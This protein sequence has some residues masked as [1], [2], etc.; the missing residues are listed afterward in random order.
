MVRKRKQQIQILVFVLAACFLVLAGCAK[1]DL[2][3]TTLVSTSPTPTAEPSSSAT[4]TDK[5]ENGESS[6][7]RKVTTVTGEI[8]I[9]ANPQR[10]VV[11]WYIGDVFTL[12]FEPAGIYAWAQETMPFYDKFGDIPIIEKWDAESIMSLDP[13]LIVT[14]DPL[15]ADKFS[16]IA[17]VLVVPETTVSPVERLQFLGEATG[18]EAE[19]KAAIKQFEDKLAEAQAELNADIFKDKTFSIFQDWGADSY[20]VFYETG[21]RGG[22]LLYEHLHLKKPQKLEELVKD[23]GNGRGSLSYEVAA[24]YF[25]DYVIWFLMEDK[26]SEFAQTEIWKSIP[27]VA[28]G[29]I[30]E[31][32]GEYTGLFFYSDVVSMTA[33]M[34]LILNKLLEKTK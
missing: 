12:G 23:S 20:G 2:G 7:T 11:N 26:V 34:E 25:G 31:I 28:A 8:E 13:D 4:D 19:A 32:P 5:Q 27:A 22:T 9:P 29:N 21:S 6:A 1:N 24:Q 33:Q 17:P 16:K 15:D 3:S 18:R 30:I 14:Y 10:I